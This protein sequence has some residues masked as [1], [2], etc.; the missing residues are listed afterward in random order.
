MRSIIIL[1]FLSFGI[2]VFAQDTVKALFLGN[3]YT[4]RNDMPK[5]VSDF[6]VAAGNVLI[7][8]VNT[9][10]GYTLSNHYQD[11]TSKYL[12]RIKKWDFVVLQEQSQLP[13]FPNAEV[14]QLMYPASVSLSG[15]IKLGSECA[16]PAFYRT[17]GRKNGDQVN[18]PVWPPVCT[19]EGMD[20]LIG[21]RYQKMADT[22]S[23]VVIPVGEVWK[24]IRSV[25]PTIELYAPDE[26]HPSKVGSFAAAC[27]F[28]TCFYRED[29]TTNSFNSTLDDSTAARIKRITKWVV[30]NQFERWNIGAY[31]AKASY[32]VVEQSKG[33]LIIASNSVNSSEIK[34][35]VNDSTATEDTLELNVVRSGRYKFHLRA[36]GDCSIDTITFWLQLEGDAVSVN[37]QTQFEVFSTISNGQLIINTNQPKSQISI[38]DL[39]GKKVATFSN[40][41]RAEIDT[42]GLPACLIV[43][44]RSKKEEIIRKSVI[45]F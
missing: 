8:E 27:C 39:T 6:A 33:K 11:A 41:N 10:G 20:T 37:E 5:M 40:T 4:H 38:F 23:G 35:I 26:S 44:V 45:V 7:R 29:P 24:K 25:Y 15:L 9:Q 16:V 34:W 18:C 17:W 32:E 12:I 19:Y 2:Q 3:S 36:K 30:F 1:L 28:Y 42:N 13:S 14:E 43:E 22:N 21:L 31:D